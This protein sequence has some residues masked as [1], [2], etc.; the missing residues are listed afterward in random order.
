[1]RP[2]AQKMLAINKLFLRFF[3]C[4]TKKILVYPLAASFRGGLINT[5]IK[6]I[7]GAVFFICCG[8]LFFAV[9]FDAYDRQIEYAK[10]PETE[11]TVTIVMGGFSRFPRCFVQE[12]AFILREINGKLESD[13]ES[14]GRDYFWNDK[15]LLVCHSG[16]AMD[17]V[18]FL[19]FDFSQDSFNE[20]GDY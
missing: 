2:A 13:V 9:G 17:S 12:N 3:T 18:R 1:F 6:I 5:A 11:E 14:S 16:G 7:S 15:K 19:S 20:R 8:L 4:G 10:I